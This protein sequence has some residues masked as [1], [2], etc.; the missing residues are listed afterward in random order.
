MSDRARPRPT[1][2]AL[3]VGALIGALALAGCG[4]GQ[5]TQTSD[6]VAAVEGANAGTGQ[7]A[8]RNATF[9]FDGPVEGAAV[10][11]VGGNAPLEMAIVNT[12]ADMDRLVGASSPIA[13]S[14]QI[15][16]DMRIPGGQVLTVTGAPAPVVAAPQPGGA[17]APAEQPAAGEAPAVTPEPTPE[18]EA[19][20]ALPVDEGEPGLASIVLTGLTEDIQAGRTYPLVLTFERGGEVRF[21]VPVANPNTLREE[22]QH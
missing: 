9:E 16:G 14:V 4:A 1:R 18:A 7:I 3:V 13:S 8:I 15:T 11:A 6:Q 10:Y 5:I 21:E 20:A 22:A 19:P 2:A 12:G 17:E